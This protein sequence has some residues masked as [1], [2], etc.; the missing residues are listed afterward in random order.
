MKKLILFMFC[1]I[2]AGLAFGLEP[3]GYQKEMNGNYCLIHAHGMAAFLLPTT[4]NGTDIE[5]KPFVCDIVTNYKSSVNGFAVEYYL[6]ILN[7]TLYRPNNLIVS[8]FLHI[9]RD[10]GTYII[11]TSGGKIDNIYAG[12]HFEI[13]NIGCS[14]YDPDC[15]HKSDPNW[16]G[17]DLTVSCRSN[18]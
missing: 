13:E 18:Y 6:S 9:D 15:K 16:H 4:N 3:C 5:A 2:F 14:P 17:D 1:L 12:G 7:A 10:R 11:K 8:G